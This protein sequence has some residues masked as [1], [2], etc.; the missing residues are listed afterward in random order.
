VKKAIGYTRKSTALLRPIG[1]GKN[2]LEKV[3]LFPFVRATAITGPSLSQITVAT[4]GSVNNRQGGGVK[5]ESGPNS[6]LAS[7]RLLADI[8]CG[9]C[10]SA[11]GLGTG[12]VWV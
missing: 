8:V 2:S 3:V 12:R 7:P 10:Q 9:F 4:V 1:V 6:I 11:V 5:E